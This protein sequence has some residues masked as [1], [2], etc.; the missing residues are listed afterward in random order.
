MGTFD[1]KLEELDK[2]VKLKEEVKPLAHAPD[3]VPR[4]SRRTP[5]RV[6]QASDAPRANYKTKLEGHVEARRRR[7]QA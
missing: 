2:A 1:S 6:E 5:G 4:A 7:D 3:D